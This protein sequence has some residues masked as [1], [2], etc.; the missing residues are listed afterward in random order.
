MVSQIRPAP[1][2]RTSLDSLATGR[3]RF[4][5]FDSE[6]PLAG[7]ISKAIIDALS[8]TLSLS[9][10][11][12]RTL[13]RRFQQDR[14]PEVLAP[15]YKGPK[16]GFSQSPP[17]LLAMQRRLIKSIFLKPGVRPTKSD[18]A[19]KVRRLMVAECEALGWA[20]RKV[21]SERTILR[22]IDRI[23]FSELAKVTVSSQ[24][25]RYEYADIGRESK[26]L[27]NVVQMDHTRGNVFLVDSVDRKPIGRPWITLLICVYSRC[28][29]GF[30]VSM[31]SPSILRCGRA[32]ANAILPKAPLLERLGLAHLEYPMHGVFDHFDHDG[33]AP[34]K[35]ARLLAACRMAGI[36]DPNSRPYL[37]PPTYGAHIERLIGTILNE[38]RC[39]DGATG[40]SVRDIIDYD[41]SRDATMTV[42]EFERWFVLQIVQYHYSRHSALGR[43]PLQVWREHAGSAV[44]TYTGDLDELFKRFLPSESRVVRSVGVQFANSC[45]RHPS[46]AA[47]QGC[48]FYVHS[49][50]YNLNELHLDGP[51]GFI[52]LRRREALERRYALEQ[53]AWLRRLEAENRCFFEQEAEQ[54]LISTTMESRQQIEQSRRLTRARQKAGEGVS[55][56]DELSPAL[57]PPS[58]VRNAKPPIGVGALPRWDILE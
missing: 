31:N 52:T 43:S 29:V 7:P 11:H 41:P 55:R 35:N 56:A 28:I 2:F 12:V 30:L 6:V 47:L 32:I 37:G 19:R 16:P 26:G 48:T 46:L 36:G 45:Y 18:T 1:R 10:G 38:F 49:D 9:P 27:L 54:V 4:K 50:P 34:H 24:R 57:A 13:A 14:R 42:E 20:D 3:D 53:D 5:A 33:E 58:P 40:A 39:L 15:G 51:D 23:P 17:E 25:S 44:R 8:K 21:P 22:D